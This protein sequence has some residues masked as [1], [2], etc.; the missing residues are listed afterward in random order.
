MAHQARAT[1]VA[2][3]AP[4][5]SETN[6]P[7]LAQRAR[8]ASALSGS[9]SDGASPAAARLGSII[10]LDLHVLVN[11]IVIA[12]RPKQFAQDAIGV[13]MIFRIKTSL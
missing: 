5:Q 10:F 4:P 8:L 1:V 7:L 9:V 12:N 2:A 11:D 13:L 6:P 3:P